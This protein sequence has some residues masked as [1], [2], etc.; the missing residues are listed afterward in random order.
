MGLWLMGWGWSSQ[1][2]QWLALFLCLISVS[3]S[4]ASTSQMAE[5]SRGV[6]DIRE[7][8]VGRWWCPGCS[9]CRVP[10][11]LCELSQPGWVLGCRACSGGCPQ[12]ELCVT[13]PSVPVCRHTPT[14]HSWHLE[15]LL[16]GEMLYTQLFE[17]FA[18]S[19]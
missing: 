19:V 17:T 16:L 7:G 2:F 1:L 4:H 10:G 6:K 12:P 8:S 5:R 15:T 18:S 13:L 9:F 14:T 3:K 11:E